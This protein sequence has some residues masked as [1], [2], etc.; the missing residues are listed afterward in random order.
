MVVTVILLVGFVS[1][2]VSSASG[3]GDHG[4]TPAAAPA[5]H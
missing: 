5:K 2:V 3:H 4:G 1:M